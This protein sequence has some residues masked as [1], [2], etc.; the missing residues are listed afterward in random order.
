MAEHRVM[1]EVHLGLTHYRS[2]RCNDS[3][4]HEQRSK[5]DTK[6]ILF[7]APAGKLLQR[8]DLL[9]ATY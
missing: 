7:L 5:T 9:V 6:G 3:Q 2:K 1:S 8:S 4:P